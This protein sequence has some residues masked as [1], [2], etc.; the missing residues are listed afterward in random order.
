MRGKKDDSTKISF[1]IMYILFQPQLKSVPKGTCCSWSK[2]NS[3][4]CIAEGTVLRIIIIVLSILVL[5]PRILVSVLSQVTLLIL[6]I[7]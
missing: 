7:S 5:V 1:Q 2:Q 4:S 3:S 6:M